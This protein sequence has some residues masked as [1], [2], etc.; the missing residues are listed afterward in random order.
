LTTTRILNIYSASISVIMSV[1]HCNVT[2]MTWQCEKYDIV[3]W[4]SHIAM[5]HFSL[6]KWYTSLKRFTCACQISHSYG[7]FRI[8][9]R[10]ESHCYVNWI[11]WLWQNIRLA[12]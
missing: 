4:D 1:W 8:A 10:T 3:T 2:F 5:S 9:M 6:I 11:T 12:L 7:K